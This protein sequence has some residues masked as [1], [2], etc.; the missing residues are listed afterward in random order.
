MKPA[1]SVI[2]PVYN[3][4]PYIEATLSSVLAQRVTGFELIVVDDG[5]T[6]G[7]GL[8]CDGY[9]ARDNRIRVIHKENGGVSSARNT[10][11]KAAE[12]DYIVLLDGDDTVS[13]DWLSALLG[14]AEASSAD[15]VISGLE[16]TDEAG[17][18][19]SR[20]LPPREGLF[21]PKTL[22]D[23]YSE[24]QKEG[25]LGFSGGKLFRRS[26]LEGEALLF[27]ETI[28]MAEDL[29]F[30]MRLYRRAEKI[31]LCFACGYRYRQNSAASTGSQSAYSVDYAAQI[32]IWLRIRQSLLELDAYHDR[33]RAFVEDRLGRYLSCALL[34]RSAVNTASARL[35][36]ARCKGLKA[37]GT[38]S[39]M[40]AALLYN[41]RL[42]RLGEC[43]AAL[44]RKRGRGKL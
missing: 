9:A 42:D 32:G 28:R 40:P 7:T 38:G 41:A 35:L 34:Y 43:Y 36:R 21:T 22:L 4:A 3:K 37:R 23:E 20:L 6:D 25:I 12:G 27:D 44:Y 26:L 10:A 5:S 11:L 18:S 39:L 30:F 15:V 24:L 33:N 17:N 31:R 16:K 8:L 13:E 14:E 1:V 2:L 19:L 29:D